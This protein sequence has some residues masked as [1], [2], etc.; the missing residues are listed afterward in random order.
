MTIIDVNDQPLLTMLDI[1]YILDKHHRNMYNFIGLWTNSFKVEIK[2]YLTIPIW[3]TQLDIVKMFLKLVH[4][5][6]LQ[7]KAY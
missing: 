7:Q 3:W 6:Q 2:S 4:G 5:H 1:I